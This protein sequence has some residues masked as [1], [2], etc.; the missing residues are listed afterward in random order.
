MSQEVITLALIIRRIRIGNQER[1]KIADLSL[2]LLWFIIMKRVI[3]LHFS[4]TRG[5]SKLWSDVPLIRSS[6]H[7]TKEAVSTLEHFMGSIM[8]WMRVEKTEMLLIS[9][10]SGTGSRPQPVL[11]G[12]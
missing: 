4:I 6:S 8:G 10:K 2:R 9:G 12:V 1:E 11:E 7:N 5:H 3:L